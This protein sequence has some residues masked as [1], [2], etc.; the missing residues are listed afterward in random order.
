MKKHGSELLWVKFSAKYQHVG[1]IEGV[2]DAVS[3]SKDPLV[4]DQGPAAGV[5]EVAATLVLQR[6]L[7][8]RQKGFS[9]S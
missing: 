7:R 1:H 9:H 5:V 4:G 8:G 3:S 6:C 2:P